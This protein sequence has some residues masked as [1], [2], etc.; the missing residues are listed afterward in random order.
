[1]GSFQL[2]YLESHRTFPC[3]LM[4]TVGWDEEGIQCLVLLESIPEGTHCN[5]C[6]LA[7]R[8]DDAR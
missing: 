6:P 1:M 8:E 5:L 7:E 2:C 4:H 3:F